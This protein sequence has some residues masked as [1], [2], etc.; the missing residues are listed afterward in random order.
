VL[1]A[2]HKR[3]Y[4]G[5]KVHGLLLDPP[6]QHWWG[7][8]KPPQENLRAAN[9]AIAKGFNSTERMK[10]QLA[11]LRLT[12]RRRTQSERCWLLKFEPGRRRRRRTAPIVAACPRPQGKITGA[13]RR[14][15]FLFPHAMF[16]ACCEY[17]RLHVR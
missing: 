11:R 7:L 4:R 1:A 5:M 14:T 3:V 17:I 8:R 15:I 16:V 2:N 6:H 10:A 12:R 9:P 13:R